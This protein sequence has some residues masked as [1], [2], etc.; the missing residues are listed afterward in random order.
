MGLWGWL[1][2]YTVHLSVPSVR[3]AVRRNELRLS[4]STAAALAKLIAGPMSE[5]VYALVEELARGGP[6]SRMARDKLFTSGD[7][8]A[9]TSLIRQIERNEHNAGDAVRYL[10]HPANHGAVRD[11]E[12]V[13]ATSTRYQV[14]RLA[15]E[16]LSG[17]DTPQADD[18]L[19]RIDRLP[20]RQLHVDTVPNSD[21]ESC[22]AVYRSSEEIYLPRWKLCHADKRDGA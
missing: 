11:L 22:I 19:R 15:V 6:Y 9:I 21:D 4:E 18:A 3:A 20:R 1:F 17:M 8:R 10:S 13:A 7:P 16:A 5:D 12:R 2:G 14:V